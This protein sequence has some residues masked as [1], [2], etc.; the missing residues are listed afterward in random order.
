MITLDLDTPADTHALGAAL[1][2]RLRAGD[3]VILSGSLG[4]GKTTLTKGIADGM[5]V[6]GLVTSPSFVIAR[7]H[8]PSAASGTTLVHVDAYRLGWVGDYVDAMNFLELWTCGSGNNNANFCNKR[9]DALVDTARHTPDNAARYR[10]YNRHE[11]ILFGPDGDMPILPIYW[12]TNVSL[13]RETIKD[14][15]DQ[16]LLDQVDLSKVVEGDGPDEVAS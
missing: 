4:S 13:Q 10:V 11:E 1:G 16:N 8:R 6:T 14:T 2:R 7:V 9:Y 15:F 12:Y 5:G 3:L